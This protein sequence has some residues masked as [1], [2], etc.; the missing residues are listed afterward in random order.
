MTTLSTDVS[1]ETHKD[2][3]SISKEI[4]KV[5][6]FLPILYKVPDIVKVVEKYLPEISGA[7]TDIGRIKVILSFM[8]E[9]LEVVESV[10]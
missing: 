2:G 7:G 3:F 10:L 4:T 6:K 8:V 9:L 1:R 5:E